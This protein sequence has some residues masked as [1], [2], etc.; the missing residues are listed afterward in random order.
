MASDGDNR[1]ST[2]RRNA[3]QHGRVCDMR[4]PLTPVVVR[5]TGWRTPKRGWLV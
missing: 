3:S 1:P 4:N 5:C 2:A